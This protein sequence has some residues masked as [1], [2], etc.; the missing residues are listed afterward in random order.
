[1]KT[2]AKIE[3]M[4]KFALTYSKL[5]GLDNRRIKI[6]AYFFD[7]LKTLL[8]YPPK[9]RLKTLRE[10]RR[11]KYRKIVSKWPVKTFKRIGPP[12]EPGGIESTIKARDI[13]CIRTFQEIDSIW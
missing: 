4:D 7:P 13:R 2:M 6:H 12:I 11:D 5:I 10:I 3:Q 1:M 9:E 8:P